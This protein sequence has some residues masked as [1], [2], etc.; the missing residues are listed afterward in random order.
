MRDEL[1]PDPDPEDA[2]ETWL[3]TEVVAAYDELRADPSC[4]ISSDEMRVYLAELYAQRRAED[5]S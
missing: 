2:V 4:A 5:D 3:R 1:R